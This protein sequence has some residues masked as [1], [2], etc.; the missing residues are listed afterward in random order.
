MAEQNNAPSGTVIISGH[1]VVGQTLAVTN[2]IT[3][4]DGIASEITYQWYRIKNKKKTKI[5]NATKNTLVLVDDDEGFSIS[6]TA[7]YIDKNDVIESVESQVMALNITAD[8]K[9][10]IEE[11]KKRIARHSRRRTVHTR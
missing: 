1:P 6:V 11:K 4:K 10:K 3:D 9:M 7:N 8:V 2:N 5:L